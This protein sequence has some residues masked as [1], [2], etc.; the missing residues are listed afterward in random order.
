MLPQEPE[1]TIRRVKDQR[2]HDTHIENHSH[3]RYVDINLE[4]YIE[5]RTIGPSPKQAPTKDGHRRSPTSRSPAAPPLRRMG[6]QPSD[7]ENHKTGKK[8]FFALRGHQVYYASRENTT[9]VA[10]ATFVQELLP[11]GP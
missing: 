5:Y 6:S 7:P 3:L 8:T 2:S 4:P 1:P 9:I 10:M 11:S